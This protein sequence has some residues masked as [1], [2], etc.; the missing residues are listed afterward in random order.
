MNTLLQ[1]SY[2]IPTCLLLARDTL[3]EEMGKYDKEIRILQEKDG[4]P[5]K[6]SVYRYS[7]YLPI[8][9]TSRPET[10]KRLQSQTRTAFRHYSREHFSSRVYDTVSEGVLRAYSAVSDQHPGLAVFAIFD[11]DAMARQRQRHIP[12]NRIIVLP[13]N[14]TPVE[15]TTLA[16]T[17]DMNQLIWINAV[18]P[19][20][21]IC[22]ISQRTC[23]FYD[24]DGETLTRVS[25]F[26]NP[27]ILRDQNEYLDVHSPLPGEHLRYST[28]SDKTNK[29]I[30]KRR[31]HFL[32]ELT[33]YLKDNGDLHRN[34]AYFVI[35]YSTSYSDL[36]DPFIRII[37]RMFPA[38]TPLTVPKNLT[39]TNEIR[40]VADSS[41]RSYQRDQIQK[42]YEEAKQK[43]PLFV[44]GWNA[45]TRADRQKNID[46]L[47][48]RPDVKKSGYRIRGGM[49]FSYPHKGSEKVYNMAPRLVKNI[50]DAGG[51]L[52]LI[53]RDDIMKQAQVAATMR[54]IS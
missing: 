26:T 20:A 2:V 24:Y 23:R 18:T 46:T 45:V 51:S 49:L 33:G 38:I 42:T 13:L 28:G 50:L 44:R 8:R 19:D 30:L 53:D 29:S 27:F 35:V 36:I 25:E 31:E 40:T 5:T 54:Y 48:I 7:A 43:H 52:V 14:R 16:R 11:A 39:D 37:H 41:I 1:Y 32:N 22:Y 15:E 4:Q 12:K 6:N 3:E 9:N 10:Q 34:N 47:F 21:V 17:Y